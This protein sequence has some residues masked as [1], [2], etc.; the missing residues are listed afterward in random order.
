MV[1]LE[2][3][4]PLG[5]GLRYYDHPGRYARTGPEPYPAHSDW[6]DPLTA[7]GAVSADGKAAYVQLYLAGNMGEALANEVR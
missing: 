7:A 3:D 2:S 4:Q 5:E 1:V 6:R